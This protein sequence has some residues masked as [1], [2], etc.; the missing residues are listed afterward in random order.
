MFHWNLPL[1]KKSEKKI[2]T[3]SE[4]VSYIQNNLRK[5]VIR[6]GKDI[7]DIECEDYFV[8]LQQ[9]PYDRVIDNL[10]N[11]EDIVYLLQRILE[12]KHPRFVVE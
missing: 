4:R 9:N 6:Y 10:E 1:L 5:L 7:K 8:S 2:E 3:I 12:E 11:V